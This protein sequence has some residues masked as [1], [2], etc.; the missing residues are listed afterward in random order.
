MIEKIKKAFSDPLEIAVAVSGLGLM[1][2]YYFYARKQLGINKNGTTN[3]HNLNMSIHDL[4]TKTNDDNIVKI[5]ITE[6]ADS[7]SR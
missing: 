6:G 5:V 7:N 1:G 2:F 4:V 3:K